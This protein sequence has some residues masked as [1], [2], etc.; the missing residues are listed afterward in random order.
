MLTLKHRDVAVLDDLT[1]GVAQSFD[2]YMSLLGSIGYASQCAVNKLLVY[3]FIEEIFEKFSTYITEEDYNILAEALN[4]L[5][6]T[7]MIPYPYFINDDATSDSTD[8]IPVEYRI[9]ED[10]VM[11]ITEDNLFRV[12]A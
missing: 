3:S 2:N 8:F 11:R 9:T 1:K 12:K 4:C 5:Y 7:C 10:K 6:G